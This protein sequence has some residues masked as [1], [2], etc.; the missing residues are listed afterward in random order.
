MELDAKQAYQFGL[1]PL[2]IWREAQ[3]QPLEAMIAVGWAI[4]NRTLNPRWW[5]FDYPSCILKKWQFSSFNWDDPNSQK[6]PKGTEP[7]WENALVAASDVF[8]GQNPDPTEGATS[9]FDKSLDDRPPQ[10]ATDGGFVHTV[11]VG[12]FHFYREV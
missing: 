10:W 11:D 4:R 12:A 7:S 6:F 2:V 3:N 5:G 8:T 1:L 9:Y